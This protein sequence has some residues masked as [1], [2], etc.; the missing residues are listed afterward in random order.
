M[1]RKSI[2][3][4]CVLLLGLSMLTL[5]ASNL[6]SSR[7]SASP[8][9]FTRGLVS[10]T[11]DD[12]YASQYAN[13][14]P[15]LNSLGIKATFYT[16]TADIG[17]GS[18][19]MTLAQMQEIKQNPVGHEIASHS[20]NHPFLTSLNDATLNA[21]LANS[22]TQLEAAGLGPIYD[23]AY[24][25]GDYD[26]RVE[27]ATKQYYISGREGFPKYDYDTNNATNFNPYEVHIKRVFPT[28]TA[29]EITTWV[30]NAKDNNEWLV[31]M[32][33]R[34]E[35]LTP[36]V[37]PNENDDYWYSVAPADFQTQMGA[38]KSAVQLNPL[39]LSE[40]TVKEAFDVV[41][42]PQVTASTPGNGTVSVTPSTLKYGDTATVNITPQAG[43][44]IASITDN[45]ASVGITNPYVIS[46]VR[47]DHNVVVNFSAIPVS[48]AVTSISPNS[49]SQNGFWV[50]TTIVGSGF[51]PG[52]TLRFE[53]GA[54]FM[55]PLSMSVDSDTQISC[56]LWLFA[57]EAGAYDVVVTRPDSQQAK[58]VGGFT[59]QSQCGQ[60]SGAG[61]L[62]LGM[63]LGLLSLGGSIRS[64]RNRRVR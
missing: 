31:L 37:I 14:I 62:M 40:V 2:L 11:F 53:K 35:V 9:V 19:Y 55:Q 6:G 17:N 30:N 38:V 47:G 3:L 63:A 27:A 45:G 18:D 46:N 54:T 57:N 22:K 50:F 44:Q 51:Q 24:P 7:A 39:T 23:F 58:L 4:F 48:F 43:Y 36:P 59:V 29:D 25:N 42:P 60:G 52:S 8:A 13:A 41:Y 56:T 61:M 15:P 10:V 32:Y 26:D 21:E 34:V 20:V 49:V 33:H 12:N 16:V 5:S 28:T 1:K 64:R